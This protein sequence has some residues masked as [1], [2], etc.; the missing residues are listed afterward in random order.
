MALNLEF[1]FEYDFAATNDN[2]L[3]DH[4]YARP[5]LRYFTRER[6]ALDADNWWRD[7]NARPVGFLNP[8]F[9]LLKPFM[10][11][12]REQIGLAKRMFGTGAI[13]ILCP[14]DK[15]ET[16]WWR[17]GIALD[18]NGVTRHEIRY[19]YP[20]LPYCNEKGEIKTSPHFPSALIIMRTMPWTHI[21][22]ANWRTLTKSL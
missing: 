9:S 4:Q 16:E 13:V 17:T 21:R 10:L 12:A 19:L 22:W 5:E 18:E 1:D 20:R 3:V 7:P 8:P 14:G 15:P 6:S 11:K 2:A